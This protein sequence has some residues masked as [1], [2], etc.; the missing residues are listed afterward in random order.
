MI[1]FFEEIK[2]TTYPMSTYEEGPF[3]QILEYTTSILARIDF[4]KREKQKLFYSIF[5]KG[6]AQKINNSDIFFEIKKFFLS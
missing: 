4:A 3:F 2:K 5:Y 6:S 1:S